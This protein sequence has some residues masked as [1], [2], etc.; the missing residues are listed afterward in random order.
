VDYDGDWIMWNYYAPF[1]LQAILPTMI[2]VVVCIQFRNGNFIKLCAKIFGERI[3]NFAVTLC[4]TLG[5]IVI[6][7]WLWAFCVLI[8]AGNA[9]TDYMSRDT[10]TT[11]LTYE[12]SYP[13]L[14]F[15][16]CL[17]N[18]GYNGD[19]YLVNVFSDGNNEAKFKT[20]FYTNMAIGKE[21]T[22]TY[23]KKSNILLSV[24]SATGEEMLGSSGS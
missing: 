3:N 19:Y 21:Y 15:T 4:I 11:N 17:N 1:I 8:P 24:K 14:P 16:I 12:K 13:S 20:T 5:I 2:F 23:G 6:T 18:W 22:I 10:E 9:I 7:V